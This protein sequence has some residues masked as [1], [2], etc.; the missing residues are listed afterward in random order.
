MDKH[1][2]FQ[3]IPAVK[4]EKVNASSRRKSIDEAGQ[5]LLAAESDYISAWRKKNARDTETSEDRLENIHGLALS[6]GGIRSATFALGVMQALA[7]HDLLKRFDYL[8]TVSGGG[9]IGSAVSWLLSNKAN[10]ARTDGGDAFSAEK[11][12]FP[13]GTDK[14]DPHVKPSDSP[15]QLAMLNYMRDH[16]HYL[17]PGDG[18]NIFA[19]LV[20]ALRGTVL[21]LIVWLPLAILV[22]LLG[23]WAPQHIDFIRNFQN[24]F[25]LEKLLDKVP[26]GNYEW[27]NDFL[28][29]EFLLRL[30]GGIVAFMLLAIVIYS[31]ST[32]VKRQFTS[33]D[34]MTWY[35][36][37]HW[38]AVVSSFLFPFT[39]FV[40][41]VGLLPVA[42]SYFI[43][44]GPLALIIGIVM[45]LREFLGQFSTNEKKPIGII[46]PI[47]AALFL[48]GFFA[49]AFQL[50]YEISDY[51]KY[52]KT[53]IIVLL[54]VPIITGYFA[55]LNYISV[56]RFYRDRLM[57][58]F[59][60]DIDTALVNDT[61]MAKGADEA[62]LCCFN[63]K[64]NPT[65]PYHL[66]NTNVV[67]ADSSDPIYS[68][69][70]GDNFIL[71]PYYCG[72]NATGWCPT[73]EY[74]AGKMTLATAFA[75]S[76][77]AINPNTGVGG[78]GVTRN[79]T[80]SLVMSLLNLGLGYW[81]HN[82]SKVSFINKIANHFN[83]GGIYVLGSVFSGMGFTEH[84]PFVEL[85]DGG[86]FENM[87][88]Y[89]LVR[90]KAS[91]I[92]VSDAGEDAEF[93]FSD[94][95]TTIR[96]I[97]T[98]F[99]ARIDFHDKEFSPGKVLPVAPN[100][101]LYPPGAKF[102]ERGY[103]VATIHY[104]D[105]REGTLV[106]LKSTLIQAASFKVKGYKAQNPAFPDQS[107][108]DQFFDDVQFEAYRELGFEIADS[109]INDP[110][111]NFSA[112]I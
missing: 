70:G 32:W 27:S 82:P 105:N 5:K 24:P 63:D 2:D 17:N 18:I 66:V 71:S 36:L 69:R 8:S 48:Y 33:I 73:H 78:E 40:L 77:A 61:G 106:Y 44:I 4:S 62:Y 42:T 86:H 23:F 67:L 39:L 58:S 51:E 13:F 37:R 107:T 43:A 29:Y 22:M 20:V 112:L 46:L 91:L 26:N 88:M 94:F 81:A 14:P 104:A 80:V 108:A 15:E 75:V 6:G 49:V 90:R 99:G 55:N 16:G 97:E 72:S 95:Q 21:N 96:R 3:R 52:K 103:M 1:S 87:A 100:G 89:E 110:K 65:S 111:L 101:K 53:I 30:C 68:V 31:L 38:V 98:D 84:K 64:E 102:S 9:Y 54:A 7:H 12:K 92:L 47:G 50:G 109:M 79:K 57:E 56:H 19:I 11:K 41:I 45:H 85:S 34:G 60:P 35:K 28:G 93:S 76:A 25:W 74:M 83:P 10:T 59:M